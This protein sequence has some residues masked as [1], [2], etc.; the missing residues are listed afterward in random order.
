MVKIFRCHNFRAQTILPVK[1]EPVCFST[2]AAK[3]F[4]GSRDSSVDIF[5]RRKGSEWCLYA[6]FQT[7]AAVSQIEYNKSGIKSTFDSMKIKLSDYE[8]NNSFN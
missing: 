6:S 7:G 4:I 3:V 1:Q 2:G 5:D 8:N